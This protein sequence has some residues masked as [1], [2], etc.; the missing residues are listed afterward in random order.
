MFCVGS[1]E[2][3]TQRPPSTDADRQLMG[4]SLLW[5]VIVWRCVLLLWH[6]GHA[7]TH[8]WP[9]E[10]REMQTPVWVS[11][12]AGLSNLSDLCAVV[13]VDASTVSPLFAYLVLHQSRRDYPV[14]TMTECPCQLSSSIFLPFPLTIACLRCRGYSGTRSSAWLVRLCSTDVFSSPVWAVTCSCAQSWIVMLI[15]AVD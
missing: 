7:R 14:G 11:F 3:P 10:T 5:S 13:H 6:I 8:H 12:P 1:R 9:S 2:A 15:W 4:R